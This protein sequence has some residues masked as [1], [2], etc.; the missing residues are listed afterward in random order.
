MYHS[1]LTHSFTHGFFSF[2]FLSVVFVWWGRSKLWEVQGVSQAPRLCFSVWNPD[3]R[4]LWPRFCAVSLS[5]SVGPATT[6]TG[7]SCRNVHWIPL[8]LLAKKIASH[9]LIPPL[10][11]PLHSGLRGCRV[12]SLAL[13]TLF[14][15]LL[16]RFAPTF[17]P[18]D[19]FVH[20]PLRHI[21]ALSGGSF[22]EL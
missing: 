9:N 7:Y 16:P 18:I 1:L 12:A 21:F 5:S 11:E 2:M 17:L 14:L 15:L 3:S 8:L 20:K 19:V 6:S 4:Q 10:C 22:V 13:L